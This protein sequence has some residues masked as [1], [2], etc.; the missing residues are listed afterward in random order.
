MVDYRTLKD[1]YSPGG[2]LS[3]PILNRER[4][5]MKPRSFVGMAALLLILSGCRHAAPPK[6][7]ITLRVATF[8]VEDI[9]TVDLLNPDQ[10]RLKKIAGEIAAIHPD[11]ILINEIQYDGEGDPWRPPGEG[12]GLNAQR[13]VDW[14]VNETSADT[15]D[16]RGFML[17]SNTGIAS[18][19]DLDNDGVASTTV[20]PIPDGGEDGSPG[21]QT[22]EGRAYGNDSYGFG[23]F[24]GQYGMALLVSSRFR[25][26]QDSV[27]TFR[28][29]LWKD[30]P[31]ARIPKDPETGEPWYSPEEWNNLRLSSK[32]I[33]D[34]PIDVG[35]GRILHILAS[36]PSPPAFDGPEKRNQYRNHDE[37]RFWHEYLSN[38]E[39]IVDDQGR[40]G[41][42]RPG[43]SFVILGDM[44][45]DVNEG[46]SLENPAQ[47]YLL[48]DPRVNGSFVPQ[49]SRAIEGLDSDDTAWWGLRVD[50]VLPSIDIRVIGGEVYRQ[51]TNRSEAAQ[52]HFPVWLDI[53]LD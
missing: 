1:S 19:F 38:A 8:N 41:G 28:K 23:M 33:W 18:G 31:D 34:V 21:R 42:L 25:I 10:V 17:P 22:P 39:F 40:R 24:P 9:R 26:L 2:Q 20:P 5:Y 50:Y 13:L 16:Y 37:I 15:L 30:L 35:D 53:A 45:A 44:N 4:N 27:R 32:S 43:A 47:K 7:P 6:M 36:H 29:F 48:D 51:T 11:I 46:N 52:D 49:G 12:T 14:F 3:L